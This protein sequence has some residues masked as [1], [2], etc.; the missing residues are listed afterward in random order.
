MEVILDYQCKEWL[1]GRPILVRRFFME[2]YGINK[3]EKV[4]ISSY[5]SIL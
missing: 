1:T 4:H 3:L 2:M 5:N